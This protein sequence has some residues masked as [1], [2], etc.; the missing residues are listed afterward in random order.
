MIAN[1]TQS[2]TLAPLL[3]YNNNKVHAQEAIVLDIANIFK[4]DLKLAQC[5]ID[6]YG[7]NPKSNR[8]DKFLH[9]SLNFL[10]I[11]NAVLT[12]AILKKLASEYLIGIGF[13]E[14]HPYVV[15][16]HDDTQ[17]PH[18]HIVT[19]KLNMNG[20][21]IAKA[22]DY[23][24][25]QRVTRSL[26]EKYNL[27]RVSSVKSEKQTI[28]DREILFKG[29]VSLKERIDIH[30][31]HALETLYVQS[32]SELVSYLNSYHLDV[33]TITI[34]DKLDGKPIVHEGLVYNYLT[35]DF[36]QNQKGIKASKLNL[37]PTMKNLEQIFI[38]NAEIHSNQKKHTKKV[39][40]SIFS[41]YDQVTLSDLQAI[42]LANN[43]KLNFKKDYVGKLVGVSFTDTKIGLKITGESISKKYTARKITLLIGEKT[44]FKSVDRKYASSPEKANKVYVIPTNGSPKQT[45]NELKSE[46]NL[47][48]SLDDC[49]FE[50]F[51][52]QQSEAIQNDDAISDVD[53]KKKFNPFMRRKRRL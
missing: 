24:Q 48:K 1:I 28:K 18:I 26:E 21:C 47:D 20:K 44:M 39:L 52:T 14:D 35:P 7:N 40:D 46:I 3:R 37:N 9:V 42:L 43:I 49:S 33:Q 36:K 27:T 31:K 29:N 22:N 10:P 17:H 15:Y 2:S 12:D 30:I 41:K 16:K 45:T 6:A 38:K 23:R 32:F 50:V 4:F 13:D 25:S 53:R 34:S 11:D 51:E 19:S 8:K 5:I